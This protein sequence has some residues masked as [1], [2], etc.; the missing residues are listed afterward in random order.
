[1]D[2]ISEE[3]GEPA[4]KLLDAL[5]DFFNRIMFTG[6][7]PCEICSTIFGANLIAL[8]KPDGGI[9]PIAV[10]FLLRRLAGKIIMKKLYGKC[11]D[12]FYPYQLGVGTPKGVESAVH[13]ARAYITSE[14]T[15]IRSFSKLILRMR[16]TK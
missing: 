14:V 1:M 12:L 15:K 10:G 8:S 7:I 5:T 6:N 13:T 4:L 16:L 11:K 2:L 3:I 9:R